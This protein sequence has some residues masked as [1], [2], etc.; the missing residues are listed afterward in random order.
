MFSWTQRTQFWWTRPENCQKI[1][2]SLFAQCPGTK[3]KNSSKV[4]FASKYSFGLAE[5]SF[6]N[7]TVF[8]LNKQTKVRH[9]ITRKDKNIFP[10]KLLCL[11]MFSWT[12]K[13]GVSTE[14][15][16]ISPKNLKFFLLNIRNWEK[17]FF[18]KNFASEFSYGRTESCFDHPTEIFFY[19]KPTVFRSLSASHKKNFLPNLFFNKESFLD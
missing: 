5:D 2:G 18:S 13:N 14:L 1:G 19:K 6:Y 7:S 11:K 3:E 4:W 9:P 16:K 17:V 8:F 15:S 12:R 10:K